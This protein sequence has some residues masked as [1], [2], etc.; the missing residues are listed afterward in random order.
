VTGPSAPHTPPRRQSD[1]DKLRRLPWFYLST[2]LTGTAVLCTVQAPLAL[3]AAELGLGEDR[4]GLLAGMMPFFQAL[5]V[6]AL[7]LLAGLGA[8]RVAGTALSL[9]YGFLLLLFLAPLFAPDAGA[10]FAVLLVAMLGFSVCRSL[11][12][13]ALVPWSQEFMPRSVRGRIAGRMALAY[14]P[15]AL[16]VSWAIRWLLDAEEGGGVERF[17]PV[18]A[19]GILAGVLGALCLFKLGGGAPEAAPRRGLGRL[20]EPLRDRNYLGFLAA[21]ALQNLVAVAL[22][23]FLLLF[24]RE[25]LGLSSGTL[26]FLAAFVPVG[27]AAGTL[28]A[29][30]FTD[31]YGTRAIRAALQAGQVML[32]LALPFMGGA[33]PGGPVAVAAAF[34]LFGALF[35]AGI[36][37]A[38]VYMLNTV[39]AASKESYMVLHYG[40][41]GVVGGAVTVAAGVLLAAIGPAGLFVAGLRIG[42]YEMLFVL[43]AGVAA[44]SALI[45]ARLREEGAITIRDFAGHFATGSPLRALWGISR[46]AS[47]TSEERRRDL[48]F[49][50]G[51]SG[52][53]LAKEE[54]FAALRDPS[55]DVRHEAI[56]ALGRIPPHPRVVAALEGVLAYR[57]LVELRY[58]ALEALGR[59]PA[60][61]AAPAVAALLDED[62]PLLRARAV[63]TLGDMRDAARL[64]RVRAMLAEDPDLDCRLAAAS[65]LG[66]LRDGASAGALAEFYLAQTEAST[67]PMAEPRS[68]VVLLA[69][70]KIL[71]CEEEF[72]REWR[73]EERDPGLAVTGLLL[74]LARALR[75]DPA[76]ARLRALAADHE[77]G[78]G[79]EALAALCALAPQVRRAGHAS[80]PAL[81]AILAR[82][83]G[84]AAPHPALL[85]LLAAGLGRA[86]AR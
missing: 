56:R 86:L 79:S 21:S 10:A 5:G 60:P 3:F 47:L 82:V 70:S 78:H 25:R 61:A 83:E 68:K 34:F 27:A 18:F 44:I 17:Y 40:I 46:Y 77:P 22:G 80:A 59:L 65:A 69:L 29:G 2:V 49:R 30:W 55:F 76:A 43:A 75:R 11:A 63:R 20:A 38:N 62:N 14:L 7:P 67:G 13:A 26:V 31:R 8:R 52:S 35:Q 51:S 6:V 36:S 12:E 64:P 16:G 58:A 9:R 48:A 53:L 72:A 24:F 42:N 33:L 73:R 66:K 39:P 85:I 74:R 19:F 57:G 45:F 54:L 41:D 50:F 28:A 84:L 37:M 71:G 23:V 15:V 32:L 1:Y 81:A 4:I